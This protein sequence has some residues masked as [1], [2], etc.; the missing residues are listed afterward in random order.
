MEIHIAEIVL[1][2]LAVFFLF[3]EYF[4]FYQKVQRNNNAMIIM[5]AEVVIGFTL[6]LLASQQRSKVSLIGFVL[7]IAYTAVRLIMIL[8]KKNKQQDPA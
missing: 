7:I 6:L 4:G 3:S 8:L 5:H 1:L 2:G